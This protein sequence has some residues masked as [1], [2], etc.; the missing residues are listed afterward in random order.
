MKWAGDADG[1]L[2]KMLVS[3]DAT[4]IDAMRVLEAG[5]QAIA[6]VKGEDGR[7]IG[8]L[9]DGDIRRALLRGSPLDS[10]GVQDA[11]RRDFAY[12]VASTSRAEVLDVMRARDIGQ[13]PVLDGDGRLCGLHTIGQIISSSE[14]ENSAV[15]LA[16]GKGT[17]LAPITEYLPKPMVKVAGRPILERLVLHLMSHGISRIYLAV[18]YMADVIEKHF[19][20]GSALGCEIHYLKEERPLGTGG[21]LSLLPK[22]VDKP[23]LV[24]NGDLITQCDFSRMLDFHERGRYAA[25][26]GMRSYAVNIPFGVARVE[27]DRLVDIREKPTE[28]VMINA[29]IYVLSREAIAH[30]PRNESY[31]ITDLFAKCIDLGM[32]VGAHIVEEDWEDVGRHEELRRARG[33]L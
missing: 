14:R 19:G 27:G 9:T 25:T 11:M 8:T 2:A 21:P 26:F 13:L 23:V 4:L 5:G 18:N 1:Q 17:R 10:K 33:E 6:F 29:G 15:I 20:D 28:R 30:V 16:G 7:I 31:P 32:P 22:T 3:E 12:A 24:L